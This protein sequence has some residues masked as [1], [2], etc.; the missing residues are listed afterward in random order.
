MPGKSRRGHSKQ[1]S[2]SKKKK[3]RVSPSTIAVQKSAVAS[4]PGPVAAS[5]V[6]APATSASTPI[7]KPIAIRYPFVTVELRRIGILAGIMLVILVVL[8][9]VLS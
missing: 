3:S 9:L 6:A 4:T 5:K 1:L 8:A 7:R 2:Q